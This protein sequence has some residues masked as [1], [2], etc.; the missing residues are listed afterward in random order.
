MQSVNTD[1]SAIFVGVDDFSREELLRELKSGN[2]DR[3]E[4]ARYKIFDLYV[5]LVTKIVKEYS[6]KKDND[7]LY[8]AAYMELWE[9]TEKLI[10]LEHNNMTGYVIVSIHN[11][12]KECRRRQYSRKLDYHTAC[13]DVNYYC[14]PIHEAISKEM[15][16]RIVKTS[17]EKVILDLRLQGYSDKEIGEIFGHNKNWAN[18]IRLR[19]G[20]RYLK[21][22]GEKR[23]KK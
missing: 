8:N 9:L 12:M 14:S 22:I 2:K 6:S 21:M 15:A 18:V 23:W 5:K 17:Q 10:N 3:I 1:T 16:R 7:D 13:I 4:A 20:D 19:I 11:F